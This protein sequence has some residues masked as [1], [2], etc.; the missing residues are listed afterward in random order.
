MWVSRGESSCVF[1]DGF[2]EFLLEQTHDFLRRGAFAER[3]GEIAVALGGSLNDPTS[4][5]RP[6]LLGER[7]ALEV[8]ASRSWLGQ[9][10]VGS[11]RP[12][13]RYRE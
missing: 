8:Y 6:G 13:D 3:T 11:E 10:D 2:F 5:R 7:E 9:P 4:P 1:Q 12:S